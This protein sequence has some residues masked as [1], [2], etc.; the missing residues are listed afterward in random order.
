MKKVRLAVF[1]IL[2]FL[3]IVMPGG[4]SAQCPSMPDLVVLDVDTGNVV[5]D[6]GTNSLW[7]EVL[8]RV[9][10]KG[11]L[12]ASAFDVC[13]FE[14]LD[15]DG[16]FSAGDNLLGSAACAGLPPKTS[17][18]ITVSVSGTS[19][20]RDNLIHAAVDCNLAVPEFD[21]ENNC[22]SSG[23]E[24]PVPPPTGTWHV[25]TLKWAWGQSIPYGTVL[26]TP[27]VVNLTDDNGDSRVDEN[28]VPDVVFVFGDELSR[29]ATG[30]LH[31][32]SGDTGLDLFPSPPE[33]LLARC[34]LAAG[35]INGDGL[36]EIIGRSPEDSVLGEGLFAFSN[37]GTFLWRS[38]PLTFPTFERGGGP[39]LADLD[40]DGTPEIV[41]GNNV[42]RSDGTLW[43][44]GAAGVGRVTDTGPLSCVADLD[45][46]G[47]PEVVAG[48]TAYHCD[49]SVYWY[50]DDL[51]DGW[52][53]AADFDG[54]S[55][56]EVVL[57]T[58]D[59]I[60]VGSWV[61][62]LEHD[63][64]PIWNTPLTSTTRC[65]P[66][67]PA[68]EDFDG[69]GQPEIA[70]TN[71]RV[72][73]MI[74]SDGSIVWTH[75]LV[76]RGRA[77]SLSAFDF[78]RDGVAEVVVADSYAIY[79]INGPSGM[80]RWEK[81]FMADRWLEMPV[82]A[83]IDADAQAEILCTFSGQLMTGFV[84]A[85]EDPAGGWVDT[86]R[87]WNQHTHH[88]T[89]VE[90][91]GTVPVFEE[92]NWRHYNNFRA[93]KKPLQSFLPDLTV[94]LIRIDL[95]DCRN[96]IRFT[97]RAGNGGQAAVPSGV[98]LSLYNGDPLSGG[99]LIAVVSLPG[100]LAPGEFADLNLLWTPAPPPGLY[101]LYFVVDDDGT[102]GSLVGECDETNNTCQTPV[103]IV[104]AE[105]EAAA[106][107]DVDICLGE[108]VLLDGSASTFQDCTGISEYRWLEGAIVIQDWS[109]VP[110]VLVTPAA[111]TIY[112]L[113][114]RCRQGPDLVL[115]QSSDD[116]AV[117]VHPF[118]TAE[119]GPDQTVCLTTQYQLDGSGSL[120]PG[121]SA[122]AE[123]R[124]WKG[125]T[126]LA[127]WS[128]Q[129]VL[130]RTAAAPGVETVRLEVRCSSAPDCTADD[131]VA[132]TIEDC[133]LA[134]EFQTYGASMSP[135]GVEIRW[136][137]LSE[138]G[139]LGFV[140]EGRNNSHEE[141]RGL[142]S[143]IVPAQ[144]P[145][146]LYRYVSSGPVYRE[147]RIREIVSDGGGDVTSYF[148]VLAPEP[149]SPV[150]RDRSGKRL[151]AEPRVRSIRGIGME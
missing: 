31:A 136:V 24:C 60:G 129:P 114:T 21:E 148:K 1:S 138:V 75:P 20:F 118:P 23:Y 84:H 52:P 89:N 43:W 29:D 47:S 7:G 66:G 61:H 55:Y 30:E 22:F 67:P 36:P 144:G 34:Q 68:V 17:E 149:S 59:P 145:G 32:V 125:A 80:V 110:T 25:P 33:R 137:T 2:G 111:S 88:I 121:C 51:P 54:D 87:I 97:A 50:R 40:G 131:E 9:F 103:E 150:G 85:Y 126:L 141:P 122:T 38:D 70:I 3:F 62:L 37:T 19:L 146:R 91:G 11:S 151:R 107:P 78:E 134:V 102:G 96:E 13:A 99:T 27:V 83:D 73:Y 39:T 135:E 46:D 35:D 53:A 133:G 117:T 71:C 139:T 90:E 28:D 56:P 95:S 119:A 4:I 104:C 8:V 132:V 64:A 44:S 93:Q 123:Y 14:D 69:D 72:C 82:V 143:G 57:A 79:V 147:Y 77:Y 130:G 115:C 65:A 98:P 100:A 106:G 109:A 5:T 120:F 15:G 45:L 49:G 74:D 140:V 76:S 16:V 86:W 101:S 12:G 48:N 92:D 42:F 63:G 81:D 18:I 108:R 142:H 26:S 94:S 127:G 124:W 58:S 105:C 10:N 116:I 128:D 112:T 6:C 41:F 113:E